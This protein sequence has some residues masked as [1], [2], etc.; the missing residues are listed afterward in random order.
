[1]LSA[2]L[3]VMIS[4]SS[5][6]VMPV[7]STFLE[8]SP[9]LVGHHQPCSRVCRHGSAITTLGNNHTFMPY[10]GSHVLLYPLIYLV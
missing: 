8:S 10:I 2:F 5:D 3:Q 7:A 6:E 1:M 4:L 9:W